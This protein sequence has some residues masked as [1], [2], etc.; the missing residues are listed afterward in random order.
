MKKILIPALICIIILLSSIVIY[1][2]SQ[3]MA[4]LAE[5]VVVLYIEGDVT[6]KTQ[7]SARW[8]DAT[9]DMRLEGGDSLRT[10]AD[11]WAEIGIVADYENVIRVNEK[12]II[13]LL[14]LS[15]I[16]RIG[17]LK[18]EIRSLVEGI[19]SGSTFEI[20]TPLAVCG[21]R[22]TGWD[23]QA[24]GSQV[25]VDTYED[26]VY[27]APKNGPK[28]EIIREGKR[29]VFKARGRA[30][31]M[32][33][34]PTDRIKSWNEWKESLIGR[35]IMQ[36]DKKAIDEKSQKVKGKEKNLEDRMKGKLEKRDRDS[37]IKRTPRAKDPCY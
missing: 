22:G 25:I 14:R 31:A 32:Q 11:S 30:I 23:T 35:G 16:V 17:L 10:G 21:V 27:F 1:A 12:T 34:I 3:R 7:G 19:G 4:L 8:I 33:D 29:G 26:D 37:I 15:S 36:G 24:D 9:I 28:K 5:R 13:E 6:V 18:G 2:Q 20:D